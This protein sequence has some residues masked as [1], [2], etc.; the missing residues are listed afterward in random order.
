MKH[1]LLIAASLLMLSSCTSSSK[2]ETLIKHV[3]LVWLKEKPSP[4]QLQ[5]LITSTLELKAIKEIVS[6]E[7]GTA[8]ASKRS[9]VDDSF[10]LGLIVTFKSKKDMENYIN[11]PIHQKFVKAHIKGRTSKVVVY[12]F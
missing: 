5:S 1:L 2:N 9:I 11:N 8:I 12:D 4:A 6:I 3:V 10:D 7:A